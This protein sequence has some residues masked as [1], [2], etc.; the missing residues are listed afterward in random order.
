MSKSSNESSPSTSGLRALLSEAKVK[1]IG[2]FLAVI[3]AGVVAGLSGFLPSIGAVRDEKEHRIVF[4]DPITINPS[5]EPKLWPMRSVH[6][7]AEGYEKTLLRPRSPMKFVIPIVEKPALLS[8]LNGALKFDALEPGTAKLNLKLL[9]SSGRVISET[10]VT[11][12][13][14]R[15]VDYGGNWEVETMVGQQGTMRLHLLRENGEAVYGLV[16]LD[17]EAPGLIRGHF[18][19]T[20]FVG[21]VTL[22]DSPARI[23]IV[24]ETRRENGFL[25]AEGSSELMAVVD[26]EW[27]AVSEKEDFR[28]KVRVA[29]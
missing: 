6:F 19:G 20:S 25:I 27:Q 28:M 15:H 24:A 4:G 11:L 29:S 14:E 5:V 21:D 9:T 12:T 13:V 3:T 8:Q 26:G 7:A 1:V 23:H 17:N 2:G 16:A 10:P 18:N 22:G